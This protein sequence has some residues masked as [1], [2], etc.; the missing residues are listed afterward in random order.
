MLQIHRY[1]FGSDSS[2]YLF[3]ANNCKRKKLLAFLSNGCLARWNGTLRQSAPARLCRSVVAGG[4]KLRLWVQEA[5]LNTFTFLFFTFA[6]SWR[7]PP[8]DEARRA[9]SFRLR[10]TS[11]DRPAK[12]HNGGQL[13]FCGGL[14][15]D[16]LYHFPIFT[17]AFSWRGSSVG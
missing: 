6:L 15:F 12:Q 8:K 14:V 3:V 17:F 5:E 16:T 7:V 4:G 2:L 1:C 13:G 9:S 11:A 10:F